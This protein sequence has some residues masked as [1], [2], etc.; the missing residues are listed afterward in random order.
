MLA[1]AVVLAMTTVVALRRDVP[2]AEVGLMRSLARG[3]GWLEPPLVTVMQL[4]TLALLPAVGLLCWAATRRPA[5]FLAALVAGLAADLLAGRIKDAVGRGRPAAL[6]EGF[7]PRETATGAGF[8]SGHT[9]VAFAVAAVLAGLLPARRAWIAWTL[10]ALVGVAR[11]HVGVHLPLDVVGGAALG[12]AVGTGVA[13]LATALADRTGPPAAGQG[14][15][16]SATRRST[17]L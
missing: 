1:A 6:I 16:P 17:T 12:V 9:A 13:V 7:H 2:A 3:P 8:V 4:G 15:G 5:G 10:A 14:R 11:V